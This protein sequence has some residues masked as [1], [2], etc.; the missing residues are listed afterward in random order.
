MKVSTTSIEG[1]LVLEPTSYE[2]A[3]GCFFESYNR[4]A[5]ATAGILEEFV[6]DNHSRSVRDVLRGLHYQVHAPQGKLVRVVNGEVID[7]AVDLRR[8]SPSFG[9]WTSFVLSAENRRMVWLPPGMAHGYAVL[10]ECADFLYKSTAYWMPEYERTIIWSDIDLQIDWA[11][12]GPPILSEKDR[13]GV[14]FRDAD[15]YP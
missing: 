11:L 12:K 6:Q 7:V 15:V 13:R 1:V 10:S 4:R 2:D 5:L 9:R 14:R 3:R 8:S